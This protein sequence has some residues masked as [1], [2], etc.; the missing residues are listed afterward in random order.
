MRNLLC[1]LALLLVPAGVQAHWV[2]IFPDASDASKANVAF[3]H[4]VGPS[5]NPKFLD[6]L[7]NAKLWVRTPDGDK[8][9]EWTRGDKAYT[10]AILGATT[11]GGVNSYGVVE[12]KDA[13][14][15]RLVQCPKLVLGD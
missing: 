2:W 9:V 11:I 14:P 13:K 6:R 8:P 1:A 4:H 5:T 15:F 10:F 12:K 3:D 7:T